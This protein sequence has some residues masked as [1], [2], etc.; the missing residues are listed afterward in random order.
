MIRVISKYKNMMANVNGN[1]IQFKNGE[2][3]VYPDEA[4]ILSKRPEYTIAPETN[5]ETN[6]A[7]YNTPLPPSTKTELYFTISIVCFNNLQMTKHCLEH[8]KK[9]SNKFKYEVIITDNGSDQGT[10]DFLKTII[11]DNIH[12]IFNSENEGF[13]SPNIKALNKAKGKY[14]VI[15]NNDFYIT[16]PNW[17]EKVYIEFV[18]DP[19]IK[20]VGPVGARLNPD[21]SGM[22][23]HS[24]LYDYIEGSCLATPTEFIKRIGL[25][26]TQLLTFAYCEDSDLS[27][28]VRSEGYKIRKVGFSHIHNQGATTKKA[29]IFPLLRLIARRNEFKFRCKWDKYLKTRKFTTKIN[30]N[31]S[32]QMDRLYPFDLAKVL[33]AKKIIL[34][35]EVG[36]GDVLFFSTCCS[37]LKSKNKNLHITFATNYTN[38]RILQSNPHIDRIIPYES[39]KSIS[40]LSEYD[41]GI[42]FVPFFNIS[43]YKDLEFKQHRIDL[44]RKYFGAKQAHWDYNLYYEIN[45]LEQLWI[46]NILKNKSLG[47]GIVSI[48][49]T[50][51]DSK[52]NYNN[53]IKLVDKFVQEGY[54]VIVIDKH[55]SWFRNSPHILNL[56]GQTTLGQTAA[57]INVSNLIVTPDTGMLHIA[58]ALNKNTITFFNSFPSKVRMNYYKN[59][60]AFDIWKNCNLNA[61][62]QP[63]LYTQDKPCS[64]KLCFRTIPP[65]VIFNKAIELGYLK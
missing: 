1:V 57:V 35:R 4:L 54:F 53:N 56:T 51:T 21:G 42:H 60:Y 11:S 33:K 13:I 12:V 38:R 44:I 61:N 59:C 10:V 30:Y 3:L 20:I 45:G 48:V 39:I 34:A 31:R 7:I 8:L 2:A 40:I 32:Y 58:G 52:R 26:D 19:D 27:L 46:N 9:N 15:L 62:A 47:K 18:R 64:M 65:E 29:N 43:N 36:I 49:L 17:L 14:F 37:W 6:I 24:A 63:C 50:T 22:E 5:I 55:R 41:Y 25:F 23:E 16:D 28:R